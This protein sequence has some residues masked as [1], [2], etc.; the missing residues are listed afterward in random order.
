[1]IG[2]GFRTAMRVLDKGRLAM[3]ASSVG[4]AQKLFE[5]SCDYAKQRVQFGRPIAK[6]QAIQ[7]ILADMA[8]QIYAGRQM[9][10]HGAWLRDTTGKAVIKEASMIKLFCTEM[11]NR[12]AEMAVQIH[13]GMGYLK[14][15]PVE[16]IFRDLHVTRIYEGTSEVQ[17]LVIARELLRD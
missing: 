8:T 13:G 7:F 9:V 14:K 10:Y 2:Q 17:R 5:L 12:V 16:R 1:M 3:G 6:F 4:S 11:A 15:L